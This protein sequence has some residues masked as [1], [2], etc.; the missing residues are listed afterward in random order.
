VKTLAFA[1]GCVNDTWKSSVAA[2]FGS[3]YIPDC[4]MLCG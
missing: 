3:V 1:K 2:K 4:D